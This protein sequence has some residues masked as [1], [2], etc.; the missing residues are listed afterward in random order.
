MDAKR[1]QNLRLL[2]QFLIKNNF[3]RAEIEFEYFACTFVGIM[4]SIVLRR[5]LL[6]DNNFE[7]KKAADKISDYLVKALSK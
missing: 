2:Y 5:M 6:I 1:F 4:E 7:T 3:I